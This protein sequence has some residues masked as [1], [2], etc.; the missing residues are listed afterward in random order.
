MCL[1]Y[2]SWPKAEFRPTMHQRPWKDLD[3]F[4]SFLIIAAAVLVTFAFQNA[5]TNNTDADPWKLSV[6]IGPLVAGVVSWMA[7]LAWEITFERRWRQKMAA[8]PLVLFRNHVF[9][10]TTLNTLLLGFAYLASLYAIPLRLQVVNG[11]GPIMAGVLMLPM[12]GATGFGSVISGVVS[13]RKNHLAET[14]LAASIMVTLGLALQTTVSDSEKLEPKFL[15]FMVFIGLG[16]GM[17][18]SSA[19][20]FT[21]IEAPLYEHGKLDSTDLSFPMNGP[22]SDQIHSAAPA[23][24]IISQSRMLGGSIGIAMSSAVLAA[25]QRAQLAGIVPP[26]VLQNLQNATLTDAQDAALRKTYNDSF[27][28]TM[29]I[30]AIIAGIG[31]ILTIGTYRRQRKSLDDMR[32]SQIR[33]E[34][35][36]RQQEK[37][38]LRMTRS[39]VI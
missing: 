35:A 31:A 4:G 9:A 11:K 37:N 22:G 16:Y 14:M 21:A 24:G 39:N 20:M 25:Q 36:R 7:L 3:F 12:L 32:K 26:S 27:T 34:V 29:K 8:L 2:L 6:F 38:E 23:Q 10:A 1:F 33:E 13:K 30:C 17:I 15:G 19:T 5:G 28:Q 18:T